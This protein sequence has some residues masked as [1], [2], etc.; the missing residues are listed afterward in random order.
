MRVF[1]RSLRASICFRV[2]CKCTECTHEEL[3][4]GV[5]H[6]LSTDEREPFW[7]PTTSEDKLGPPAANGSAQECCAIYARFTNKSTETTSY[8]APSH[9]SVVQKVGLACVARANLCLLCR[10]YIYIYIYII[11][12]YIYIHIYYIDLRARPRIL[13][14]V[15]RVCFPKRSDLDVL[16]SSLLHFASFRM[17]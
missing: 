12:I 13:P 11:C 9:C 5:L 8:P 6:L 15:F 4:Q 16:G 1:P 7:W 2:T 17:L 10:Y 3:V 14:E